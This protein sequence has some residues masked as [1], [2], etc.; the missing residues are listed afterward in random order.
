[1]VGS[2]LT[3]AGYRDLRAWR[4]AVELADE[5]YTVTE[6]WPSR[7]QFGLT[8]QT[9]RAAVSVPAN[10]AEGQGRLGKREFRHHCSISNGS[11]CELETLVHLA[12][13]RRFIDSE[14]ELKL[15]ARSD[16]VGKVLRG[17]IKSLEA[18]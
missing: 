1:M 18:E 6:T 10:I 2:D 17:L 8:S 11:I 4:L 16:D 3:V 13:L 5:I 9:R 15:L 12:A 7:E 14:T